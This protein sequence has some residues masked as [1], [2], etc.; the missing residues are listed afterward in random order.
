MSKDSDLPKR[1]G[2]PAIVRPTVMIKP[3]AYQPTKAELE[4]DMRV[5]AT[6]EEVAKAVLRQV[7]IKVDVKKPTG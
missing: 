7:T 5:N 1:P 3:A 2:R 4:E 6:P